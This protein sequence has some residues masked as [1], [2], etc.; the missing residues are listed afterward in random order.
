[1]KLPRFRIR[2]LLALVLVAAL[3]CAVWRHTTVESYPGHGYFLVTTHTE[4]QVYRKFHLALF[5]T[6]RNLPLWVDVS[7]GVE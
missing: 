2:A 5:A 4:F 6:N 3:V 7:L 1:M